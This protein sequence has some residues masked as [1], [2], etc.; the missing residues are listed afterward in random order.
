MNVFDHPSKNIVSPKFKDKIYVATSWKLYYIR[1]C[2]FMIEL[3]ATFLPT[4]VVDY[5]G[6]N[7]IDFV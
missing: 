4:A 5:Y 6:R 3:P 2:I 7:F 1:E